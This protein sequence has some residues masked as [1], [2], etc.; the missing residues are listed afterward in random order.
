[1]A[2]NNMPI[3]NEAA[4]EQDYNELVAIR[5]EKLK[6][7]Q[8]AGKDPFANTVWPQSDFAA[9]IKENF[10]DLPEG[11]EPRRVCMAPHDVQA[12]DGQGQLCR[13]A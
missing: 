7:L 5:R 4:N 8:D 11:E 3:Q 6:A 12:R 9:E 2:E 13:F 1:M 10:V